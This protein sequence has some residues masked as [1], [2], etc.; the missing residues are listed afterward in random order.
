MDELHDRGFQDETQTRQRRA[1]GHRGGSPLL[2]AARREILG[3]F[4]QIPSP[5]PSAGNL[6]GFPGTASSPWQGEP[7]GSGVVFWQCWSTALSL[8][9]LS[10]SHF[11]A[12]SNREGGNAEFQADFEFKSWEITR[13]EPLRDVDPA[14]PSCPQALQRGRCCTPIIC[15]SS[16]SNCCF[17]VAKRTPQ[18]SCILLQI[19]SAQGEQSNAL[20][21]EVFMLRTGIS[22]FSK[23]RTKSTPETDNKPAR[24]VVKPELKGL[25]FPFFFFSFLNIRVQKVT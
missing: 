21:W 22:T 10:H 25:G 3:T 4:S 6:L 17:F 19:L 23:T 1:G 14:A 9:S 8:P 16:G 13:R 24:A 20:Q 12:A 5:H 15:N 18:K 11:G 7:A 2:P